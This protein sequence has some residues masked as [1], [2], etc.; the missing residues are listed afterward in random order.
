MPTATPFAP[1]TRDSITIFAKNERN[2][3]IARRLTLFTSPALTFQ[4][5]FVIS[6]MIVFDSS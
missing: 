3:K 1:Q 4:L 2:E 6:L 5:V